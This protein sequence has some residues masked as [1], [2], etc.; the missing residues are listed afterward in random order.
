MEENKESKEKGFSIEDLV[1][2][3]E[4]V[5]KLQV[6]LPVVPKCWAMGPSWE[7][8]GHGLARSER[9]QGKVPIMQAGLGPLALVME[10]WHASYR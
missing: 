9:V 3:V 7:V 6:I 4:Q 5:P 8:A 1:P 10:S 2:A